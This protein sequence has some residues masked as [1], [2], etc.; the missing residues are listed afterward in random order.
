MSNVEYVEPY[1]GGAAIALTLLL[2]EYASVIHINDLSRP[3]YAF[4]H[5]ALNDT[6]ELCRRVESVKV[7]MREWQRQRAVYKHR[8]TADL[9]DLGFATLFLNRTNRSGI[10]GGGAIGGLQQSGEWL[11]DARFNKN[12]LVTRIRRI[13]RYRSRIKLYQSDAL[14]FTNH[15]L[16]S[17]G[18]NTFAFYDPP[19]IENSEEL[20]LNKYKV[21]DHRQLAARITQLE[22]PW[23][24]TYDYAA[25][26][27]GL[28]QSHRRIVYGLTYSAQNRYE[29]KEVMFLSDRLKIP[30]TWQRPRPFPM[31]HPKSE[32]PVYGILEGR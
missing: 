26:R 24:V 20:Y 25:V 11:L 17:M 27:E 28:Y 23:I 22:Q 32:H 5:T 31:K 6:V 19:Y 2:E 1:A 12:D 16:A 29:G 14:E 13:G 3:V 8:D 7:T 21:E 10:I 18:P 30:P 9:S 15:I 4:W